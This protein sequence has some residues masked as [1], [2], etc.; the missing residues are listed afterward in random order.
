MIYEVSIAGENISVRTN[1][2]SK[3][4]GQLVHYVNSKINR[5]DNK[6]ASKETLLIASLN[7]AEDLYKLQKKLDG[8]MDHLETKANKL[9][10]YLNS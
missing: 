8:K 2:D 7:I 10:K 5:S 1:Q 3:T 4:V 9:L 6:K